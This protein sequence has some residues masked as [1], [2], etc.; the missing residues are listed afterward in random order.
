MVKGYVT[1]NTLRKIFLFIYLCLVN[2]H[3][4]RPQHSLCFFYIQHKKLLKNLNFSLNYHLPISKINPFRK[5]LSKILQR[6]LR[7]RAGIISSVFRWE[8]KWKKIEKKKGE[9]NCF[10]YVIVVSHEFFHLFLPI[11]TFYFLSEYYILVLL[12]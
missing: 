5:I 7:R 3:L 1:S 11:L 6:L 10:F 12:E 9:E 8:N 2:T 4:L